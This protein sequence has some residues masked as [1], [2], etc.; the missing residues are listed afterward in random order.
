MVDDIL[1]P[2]F[3]K[4]Q[5]LPFEIRFGESQNSV[6]C[7]SC[8]VQRRAGFFVIYKEYVVLVCLQCLAS[9][10]MKYQKTHIFSEPIFQVDAEVLPE[11]MDRIV[12]E[13]VEE[14]KDLPEERVSKIARGAIEKI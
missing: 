13:L 4:K 7:Q 2:D 5:Q 12:S 9:G 10:I 6:L 8:K 11:T 1:R 14:N 3:Q